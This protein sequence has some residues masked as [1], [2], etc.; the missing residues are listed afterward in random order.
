MPA[1]PEPSGTGTSSGEGGIGCGGDRRIEMGRVLA[2][3]VDLR[4]IGAEQAGRIGHG[5]VEHRLWLM[6]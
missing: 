2:Q 3:Q 6:E 5:A 1:M 4:A